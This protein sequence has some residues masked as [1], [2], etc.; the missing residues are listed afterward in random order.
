M[1]LASARRPAAVLVLLLATLAPARAAAEPVR[2]FL[3]GHKQRVADAQTVATFRAKILALV[4]A[5]LRTPD[6]VQAGVDD[7]ASHLAPGDAD[8]PAL[9]VVHFPEATGLVAGLIGS[10]GEAA[11]DAGSSTEA[12][13]SL[14]G[15]YGDVIA[16][17]GAV[18]P[19]LQPQPIRALILALTDVLYRAV[20]ETFREVAMRY[21]V[22]VSVS[23]DAAPARRVAAA[24]EPE[25]VALLRDP[26]EPDRDYAYVA[27]SALP[28]NFVFLFA[29]DGELLVPDGEGGLLR[30]PSE[31]GGELRGIPK[32]YLTPIEQ[33]LDKP[34][35]GLSLASASLRD[36]DVLDTP[37][38][39]IGVVISKDAWMPD[40]NERY[41]LKGA[42]FLL[43]SEAF[44]SWAYDTTEWA[45]DVFKSGGYANLQTRGGFLYNVAPSLTGNL[46]DATFDGQSA[47][48][49]RRRNKA[50]AGPRAPDNGFIGQVA[51]RGFLRV[52]PWIVPDPDPAQTTPS[53]AQRREQ[54]AD[55]GAPLLPGSG[56]ACPASLAVGSCENGY[57][58]AVLWADLELPPGPSA[59]LGVAVPPDPTRRPT[60]FGSSRVVS[61]HPTGRQRHPRVAARGR[62]VAVVWDDTRDGALP[63]VYLTLSRDGGASFGPALKV[64]DVPAG[65]RT[66]LDADVAIGADGVYVVWQAFARGGDDDAATI[67]LARFALD[68]VKAT[69]DVRVDGGTTPA[70]RWQPALALLGDGAPVVA[71]IDER[72]GGPDGVALEHLYAA[73]G[74]AGG[75]SFAPAVRVDRGTPTPLAA[76]LDNKWAPAM[77]AVGQTVHVAWVDFRD[78]NWD[79]YVARST[80]GGRS[81]GD[82]QRVNGFPG[83]ERICDAP[84][85]GRARGDAIRVAWTDVRARE[86]DTNLFVADSPDGGASWRT[87]RRLDRSRQGFD[88]DR[89]RPSY[90]SH[91]ALARAGECG[92][93]VWQD[94][95]AG[96]ADVLFAALDD[97]SGSALR[98]ERV[99]DTGGGPSHQ[100]RPHLAVAGAGSAARCV[101]VWEDDREG[102][103]RI[104]TAS[105]RC[106]PGA[107]VVPALAR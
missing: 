13:A 37:V 50:P 28:R 93:A 76:S 7:V 60:S 9:A 49:V 34:G 25:L 100:G 10:R 99:D 52:A 11:R 46:F 73:R 42:S 2:V 40:V 70:G 54:L 67:E 83:F 4:D 38:G 56:V 85:L 75:E 48:L 69:P 18:F 6:L 79:V 84:A 3:V 106:L 45:P 96:N 35:G 89:D 20:Y 78:Y 63:Q 88:P 55:A 102:L 12:F 44:S 59:G 65:V 29:P 53:L 31:T 14:L 26:D 23:F 33:T 47:I 22:H 80:D 66:E 61:A 16:H 32:A 105:R 58:E 17:Y 107:Q 30:A 57:R 36:L 94:D 98:E 21:G 97:A 74:T 71:W 19:E 87:D 8:A 90:Q 15:P 91:V 92:F 104:Y 24:D 27:T 51:D 103:M 86:P 77:L 41:D 68:G 81:F 82:N 62:S 95:R 1:P 101:V 64:S 43:Q 5:R 72:D 39:A